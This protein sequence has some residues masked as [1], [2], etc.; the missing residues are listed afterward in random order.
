MFPASLRFS[1]YLYWGHLFLLV[2]WKVFILSFCF[3]F[4]FK[5][6]GDSWGYWMN[7]QHIKWRY[8]I[9]VSFSCDCGGSAKAIKGFG[10]GCIR[11]W[12]RCGEQQSRQANACSCSVWEE[13]VRTS[14]VLSFSFYRRLEN[15]QDKKSWGRKLSGHTAVQLHFLFQLLVDWFCMIFT[16]LSSIKVESTE[17]V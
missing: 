17:C 13:G 1:F 9:G 7:R 11:S 14:I 10:G 5:H 8:R 12:Y 6:L 3:F 16:L 2:I 15:F 4:F